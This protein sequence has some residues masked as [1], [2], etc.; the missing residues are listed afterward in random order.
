MI[1]HYSCPQSAA[2]IHIFTDGACLQPQDKFARLCSWGVAMTSDAD[3][4]DFQ[5]VACSLLLGS[6]QTI[7]RAE[8]T[9]AL[10]ALQ[11]AF[12]Y[13]KP[14]WLWVD[15][16]LVYRQLCYMLQRPYTEW[17][18][19]T[20]NHDLLNSIAV[21]LGHVQSLC[22]G[23]QKVCS[24][25][26][27][28]LAEDPAELWSF[29]GNS[30]ADSIATNTFTSFPTLMRAW[31][32]MCNDLNR[33]R[34]CRH[35]CHELILRIAK[36]S[37]HQHQLASQ[38]EPQPL[39]R[40]AQSAMQ[41]TPWLLPPE[42]LPWRFHIPALDQFQEWVSSLHTNEGIVQ[43]WSWWELY[44]DARLRYPL[45]N[46]WYSTK[47]HRW[48]S[49]TSAPD[50]PFLKRTR[51]FAKFVTQYAKAVGIHLPTKLACPAS[52]HLSFWSTTLPVTTSQS[53]QTEVD[54]WLG[55]HVTGASRT[56]DLRSVP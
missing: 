55:L 46:P 35:T 25:Q 19:K 32:T 8:L 16:Q 48:M 53:R 36:D 45:L 7:V 34:Q 20:C 33:R 52:A 1:E 42:N 3:L 31:D 21:F 28:K 50:V 9:A 12:H 51:S 14:F 37:M 22:R 2:C 29:H 18:R 44:I 6:L 39:P 17:T 41:M 15:N 47:Q 11:L 40:L 56:S 23:I 38:L 27:F 13:G 54:R 43:R 24:H 10:V 5:P 30:H 49:G 26:D 4:W